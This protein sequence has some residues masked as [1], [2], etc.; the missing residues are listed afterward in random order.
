MGEEA[1]RLLC[2]RLPSLK[3]EINADFAI[4]NA[5]NAAEGNGLDRSSAEELLCSGADVLT[6]GNHIWQ[7]REIY[8]FLDECDTLLRPANYRP[9][10]PGRGYGIYPCGGTRLLVMNLMGTVFLD[11]LADPFDTVDAILAKEKGNYDCA[12]LDFHAEATSEKIALAWYLD[13]RASVVYGT[14]THVQTADER[15]LPGGTGFLTDLGMTG[16]LDSA[17][18]VRCDR[19]IERLRN[20]TPVRFETA[21]GKVTLHGACFTVDPSSAKATGAE[22]LCLPLF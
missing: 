15:I 3:R 8:P 12:I 6:S 16:P 13:G 1:T 2:R 17:L 14:H 20:H 19:V 5:E 22:R 11:P 21:K 18:G 10:L 4:V 9:G 7:K